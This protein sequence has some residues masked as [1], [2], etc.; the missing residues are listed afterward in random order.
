MGNGRKERLKVGSFRFMGRHRCSAATFIKDVTDVT[1]ECSTLTPVIFTSTST[2]TATT[3]R[4]VSASVTPR[5][6]QFNG[7]RSL[8]KRTAPF[9]VIVVFTVQDVGVVV[10][11]GLSGCAVDILCGTLCNA[12]QRRLCSFM[13]QLMCG[14][15]N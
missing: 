7:Q 10:V 9:T 4:L 1:V 14:G 3:F 15:C 5:P 11:G 13:R 12:V 2:S 6:L 8:W